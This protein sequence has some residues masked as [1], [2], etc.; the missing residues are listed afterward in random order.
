VKTIP[1]DESA[2]D[3]WH[4]AK[5]ELPD[6]DRYVLVHGAGSVVIWHGADCWPFGRTLNTHWRELPAPPKPT[7]KI[8]PHSLEHWHD[9]KVER[10]EHN[11]R[12]IIMY[13]SGTVSGAALIGVLNWDI[14]FRWTYAPETSR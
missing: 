12:F 3:V 1:F 4:D 5:E 13:H 7:P 10:P 9:P 2:R 14:V 8:V 6:D 11:K